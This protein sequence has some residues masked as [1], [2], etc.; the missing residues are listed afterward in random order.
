MRL[1][2]LNPNTT[3]VLTDRLVAAVRQILPAGVTL[4]PV[5]A[6]RGVPYISSRSEA[7]ISGA[8]VL[9]IVAAHLPYIDAVTIAAFGDPGLDAAREAF[10][11]PVTGMTEAAR[12]CRKVC[13]LLCMDSFR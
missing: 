4:V 2:L 5:T 3:V 7:H 8:E 6:T 9:N 11:I 10:D 12:L 1:L 13:C